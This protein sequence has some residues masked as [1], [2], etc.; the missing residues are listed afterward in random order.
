VL[1][2]ADTFAA[3]AQALGIEPSTVWRKRRRFG[4]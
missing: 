4:L 1:T 3:S 2:K